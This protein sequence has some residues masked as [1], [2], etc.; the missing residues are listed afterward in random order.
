[1]TQALQALLQAFQPRVAV[2]DEH[3]IDEIEDMLQRRLIQEHTD[4]RAIVMG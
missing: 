3:R 2:L 4:M 1:M